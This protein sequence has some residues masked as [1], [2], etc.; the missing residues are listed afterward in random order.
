MSD[1]MICEAIRNVTFSLELEF[2]PSLFVAPD[3]TIRDQSGRVHVHVNRFQQLVK[4][5]D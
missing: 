4:E 5:K 2:G 1:L 3:G